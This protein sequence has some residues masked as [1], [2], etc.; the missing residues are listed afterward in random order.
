M[1]YWM[2]EFNFCCC[3]FSGPDGIDE[4]IAVS[5]AMIN[6]ITVPPQVKP[7][8]QRFIVTLI[9]GKQCAEQANIPCIYDNYK[10]V[11][12]KGMLQGASLS[13]GK[14]RQLFLKLADLD[15]V[16]IKILPT[17]P[18]D[19]GVQGVYISNVILSTKANEV[20]KY[21]GY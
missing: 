18:K 21:L 16:A 2:T 3:F 10:N 4:F 11:G 17:L 19:A 1:K 15:R 20:H 12:L 5:K 14:L 7:I 6:S 13:Q 8:F 9:E